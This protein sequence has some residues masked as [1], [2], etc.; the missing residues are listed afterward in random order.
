[1]GTR[2]L[3]FSRTAGYRHESIPAGIKAVEELASG[4]GTAVTAT[5]DPAAFT[6]GELAGYAAVVF[7]STTGDVLG[8]AEQAA[9]EDYI[10]GGGGYAG[11]H[12]AA[13]SGHDW[14]FYQQLAGAVFNGHPKIQKATLVNEDRAH[15]ATAHLGPT[16]VRTDEWYN[17]RTN[18]RGNVRVLQSVDESS[19]TGGDMGDHPITWCRPVGAGRAFYTALGHEDYAD[20][21]FRKLL[22]GGIRYAMGR[23]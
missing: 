2:I 9:F 13:D 8:R 18:P 20:E 3:V 16:W 11:I 4:F 14:P 1:M 17:F 15:P 7:L 21:D 6:A 5:E 19:Y 22:A 12:A 10:N 23:R